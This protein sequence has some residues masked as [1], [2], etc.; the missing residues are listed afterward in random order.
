MGGALCTSA[1]AVATTAARV[2]H[3]AAAFSSIN[4]TFE[5]PATASAPAFQLAGTLNIP[6]TSESEGSNSTRFPGVVFFSGTGPQDRDGKQGPLDLGTWELLDS[7]A[8]KGNVVLRWDDRGAGES[9]L[10]TGVQPAE[11]GFHDIMG[12]GRAALN[13]LK[14]RGEVDPERLFLIGHSEGGLIAALLSTEFEDSVAGLV[15]MSSLG[16]NLFDVTLMQVEAGMAQLPEE[17]RATNL[18][19]QVEIQTAVREGREPDWNVIGEEMA[20]VVRETW[21]KVL[22]IR[23]WWREHFLLDT[24]SIYSAVKCPAL[25][26]QGQADFQTHPDLDARRLAAAIVQGGKCIDMSLRVF[27]GLDHLFKP[28]GGRPSTLEMYSEDRRVDSSF[29]KTLA[30]W[31]ASRSVSSSEELRTCASV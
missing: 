2:G 12:D 13:Y 30:D 18:K 4:V 14:S 9:G 19:L 7:L 29:I 28:T 21:E 25:V 27:S 11:M 1:G 26:T 20:P 23:K 10:P 5:R 16:R 22:P 24:D 3:R 6:S 31:I 17:A 8:S 15:I